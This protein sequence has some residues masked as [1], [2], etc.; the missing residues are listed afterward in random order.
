MPIDSLELELEA[1]FDR[2][3]GS[4]EVPVAASVDSLNQDL[5][6]QFDKELKSENDSLQ[7]HLPIR[8]LKRSRDAISAAQKGL[9]QTQTTPRDYKGFVRFLAGCPVPTV[10]RIVVQNTEFLGSGY[11]MTVYK[12]VWEASGKSQVIAVKYSNTIL[13][14]GILLTSLKTA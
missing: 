7:D 3:T 6:Q 14:Q 11:T 1:Q 12:G 10:E 5:D 8:V 4:S 9:A 2:D 13:G